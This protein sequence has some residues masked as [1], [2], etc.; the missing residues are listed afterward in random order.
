[1]KKISKMVGRAGGLKVIMV[2]KLPFLETLRG[3]VED[4]GS[5]MLQQRILRLLEGAFY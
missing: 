2:M 5:R 1:M 4:G 3:D